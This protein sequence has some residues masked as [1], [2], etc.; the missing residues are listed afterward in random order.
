MSGLSG[1]KSTLELE[2]TQNKVAALLIQKKIKRRRNLQR[3][4]EKRGDFGKRMSSRIGDAPNLMSVVTAKSSIKQRAVKEA[5]ERDRK[6]TKKKLAGRRKIV[7]RHPIKQ[8]DNQ[9]TK[10]LT[11]QHVNSVSKKVAAKPTKR[12]SASPRKPSSI[13][14]MSSSNSWTK[15]TSGH[16]TGDDSTINNTKKR[17]TK[18]KKKKLPKVKTIPTLASQISDEKAKEKETQSPKDEYASMDQSGHRSNDNKSYTLDQSGHSKESS[19]N[20]SQSLQNSKQILLEF[21]LPDQQGTG[22]QLSVDLETVGDMS[23]IESWPSIESEDSY[24]TRMNK[25]MQRWMDLNGEFDAPPEEEEEE[26]KACEEADGLEDNVLDH[27]VLASPNMAEALDK[28]EE[29]SGVRPVI[30]GPLEGLG[31]QTAHV[32][33]DKGRYIEIIAP[34][35][36]NPGPLGKELKALPAGRLIPYQYA[37]RATEISRLIEGYVYDVLGWDPD[38]ICMA[39]TLPDGTPRQWDLL[40]MYGHNI[41]GAAPIYVKYPDP[42]EHPTRKLDPTITFKKF[43]VQADQDHR[44]HKL[45]TDVSGIDIEYAQ[46]PALEF[47]FDTPKGGLALSANYPPGLVFPGY[48]AADSKK[49]SKGKKKSST[50]TRKSVLQSIPSK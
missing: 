28:F 30:M 40:T 18:K 13:K 9:W 29:M 5:G 27:I 19:L 25:M 16:S 43:T 10:A 22:L 42:S 6:N 39:Q 24:D 45:I 36:E 47:S 41:G 14:S 20:D 8:R 3:P 37:I 35:D 11:G 17:G 33:M 7:K 15:P 50:T 49:S 12:R 34:D 44:V 38:H 1:W 31:V 2:P 26:E 32:G 46:T 23:S 4:V 48:N 21:E